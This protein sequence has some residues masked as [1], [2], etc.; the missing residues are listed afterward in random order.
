MRS[1]KPRA[2]PGIELVTLGPLTNIAHAT[3]RD[4]RIT[5][6]ISRCVVMG[7]NPCCEGN[8]TPAAEYNLWC[9]PEAARLVFHSGLPIELGGWQLCRG[10][11]VLN[12]HDIS[13]IRA[14]DTPLAHFCI[15]C[16]RVATEA[17]RTQSGE[18]GI[19]LPDPI[20][21]SIAL[22]PSICTDHSMHH[23]EVETD[24]ELT[25]GMTVV[26]RLGVASDDRN[27]HT[28]RAARSA[29]PVKVY[30]RIDIPRWK[31]MLFE[32]LR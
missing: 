24:S 28:W 16:N 17:Y 12:Q 26:D 19:A 14:L 11:A 5:A 23:I 10:D 21:M 31:Q 25:R 32:S 9:D 29:P 6:N 3:L 1:S 27:Q 4:P 20:A 13:R 30:W 2:N 22:D 7:G 15:D 18:S 8:V